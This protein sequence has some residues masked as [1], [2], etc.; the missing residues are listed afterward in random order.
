VSLASAASDGFN[1][2]EFVLQKVQAYSSEHHY[3]VMGGAITKEAAGRCPSLPSQL[4]LKLDIV[5]FVFPPFEDKH[6]PSDVTDFKVDEES[7]SVV[8]KAIE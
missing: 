1:L 5:C 4:W 7:D 6:K 8:R 3:K 2:V